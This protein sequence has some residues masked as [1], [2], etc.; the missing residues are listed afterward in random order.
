MDIRQIRY[1]LTVAEVKSISKAA[2]KL[3]ISQ[4][5]LSRQIRGME[6][7]LGLTLFYRTNSGLI[8]TPA[9]SILYERGEALLHQFETVM[10]EMRS[11]KEREENQIVFGAI[12]GSRLLADDIYAP[13]FKKNFQSAAVM[14]RFG[15]ADEITDALMSGD[16]DIGF[17]RFPFRH[18]GLFDTIRLSEETWQVLVTP[19]HPFASKTDVSLEELA[20]QELILPSREALYLPILDAMK[21]TGLHPLILC[22]YFEL[23]KTALLAEQFNTVVIVPESIGR[24]IREGSY[25]CR[26]IRDLNLKTGYMAVRR[27]GVFR[28]LVIQEFWDI[29]KRNKL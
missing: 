25:V 1:F 21:T 5:P 2:E 19:G 8:L 26:P 18:I 6:E 28:S 11:L 22:Y 16:V 23:A 20:R 24:N 12:D 27:A 10:A 15:T 17:V 29:I 9:G 7:E 4:P 14:Q 13:L 3:H